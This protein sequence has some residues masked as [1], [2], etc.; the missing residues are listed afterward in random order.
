MVLLTDAL[1]A[2]GRTA[3]CE[4]RSPV[5]RR[6]SCGST[7]P[8]FR[9]SKSWSARSSVD[10]LH[11]G[12]SERRRCGRAADAA[13]ALRIEAGVPVFHR[14]MDEETIPLEAG[15]EIARDQPDE[16]LLRRSGSRSS[17]CCIAATAEWRASW[18]ACVF[19]G[20]G[21]ARCRGDRSRR[22]AATIGHVTSATLVAGAGASDRARLRASRLRR[23]PARRRRC[24]AGTAAVVER[25][26]RSP[27]SQRINSASAGG[28]C[29]DNDVS[30]D[31]LH[32]LSLL[33]RWTRR[34]MCTRGS[35]ARPG[36]QRSRA[37][38][39]SARRRPSV[40]RELFAQLARQQA[41]AFRRHR[42]CRR[43]TPSG[44]RGGRLSAG[45]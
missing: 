38:S 22:A 37:S 33:R 3:T 12:R 36:D 16:R 44:P 29:R 13:E 31:P 20:H 7:M 19:A 2:S 4:R 24:L 9:D 1:G 43:E 35:A 42:I 26:C 41:Q 45:G 5:N 15:I 8:A 27:V 32:V 23:R 39:P 40:D 25:R 30:R 18:S 11:R 6:S 10:A 28:N 17:V 34:R 14:D 21:R